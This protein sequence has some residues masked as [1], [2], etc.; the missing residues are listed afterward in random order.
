MGGSYLEDGDCV[1]VEGECFLEYAY[2]LEEEYCLEE[3]YF[4]EEEYCLGECQEAVEGKE[5]AAPGVGSD[6]GLEV[7]VDAYDVE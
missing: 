1:G 5:G 4:L 2:F 3:E 6:L 7:F